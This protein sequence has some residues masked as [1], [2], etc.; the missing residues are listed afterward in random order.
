VTEFK[1]GQN[2]H[3]LLHTGGGSG[4]NIRI[5]ASNSKTSG[6][7]SSHGEGKKPPW[8]TGSRTLPAAFSPPTPLDPSSIPSTP[9]S[10]IAMVC[11]SLYHF[12]LGTF[13]LEILL[14][15]AF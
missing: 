12:L 1:Q 5:F 6:E 7:E 14:P 3:Q 9:S 13:S 15:V 8:P 10:S 2:G 11:D 4:V